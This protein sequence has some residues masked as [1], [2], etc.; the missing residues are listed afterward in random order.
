VQENELGRPPT[1]TKMNAY[2]VKK[3]IDVKLGASTHSKCYAS[4]SMN[5]VQNYHNLFFNWHPA[6]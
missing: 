5:M 4:L 1:P 2:L 6:N 3:K